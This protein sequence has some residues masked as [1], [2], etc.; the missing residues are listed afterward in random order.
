MWYYYQ[1]TDWGACPGLQTS[2]RP[3]WVAETLKLIKTVCFWL[4]RKHS[5]DWFGNSINW[6]IIRDNSD[7]LWGTQKKQLAMAMKCILEKELNIWKTFPGGKKILTI[8]LPSGWPR[9]RWVCF[10]IRT[11][12][13][14]FS[15]TSLAHQWIFCSEWVPSEWESKQLIKT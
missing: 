5:F 1:W 9:C 12:R 11:D 3:W 10:F 8:Y 2:R 7:Q 13:E 6:Q 15:I 14:K 4:F